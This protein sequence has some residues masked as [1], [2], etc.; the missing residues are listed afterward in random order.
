MPPCRGPGPTDWGTVPRWWCGV[1]LRDEVP[2]FLTGA[3][4]WYWVRCPPRSQLFVKVDARSPV[5]YGVG[6]TVSGILMVNHA[7]VI[8]V[9][10]LYT[11]STITT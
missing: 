6:D 10:S 5:P 3:K 11:R 4:R 8:D 2:Q 1:I 7:G 9:F